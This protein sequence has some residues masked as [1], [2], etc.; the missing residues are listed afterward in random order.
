MVCT[1]ALSSSFFFFCI[2][3]SYLISTIVP[4]P[5]EQRCHRLQTKWIRK[6][7]TMLYSSVLYSVLY[8]EYKMNLMNAPFPWRSVGARCLL[9]ICRQRHCSFPRFKSASCFERDDFSRIFASKSCLGPIGQAVNGKAK[10]FQSRISQTH[11]HRNKTCVKK[12]AEKIHFDTYNSLWAAIRFQVYIYRISTTKAL[13]LSLSLSFCTTQVYLLSF[14]AIC[15]IYVEFMISFTV[16]SRS[17]NVLCAQLAH[18]DDALVVQPRDGRTLGDSG[19]DPCSSSVF[20]WL[21]KNP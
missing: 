18:R 8:Q 1:T 3:V 5:R 7:T 4:R 14:F 2:F 20:D 6:A 13:C 17:W 10:R 16:V 15:W 12:K 11:R 21:G 9:Y 19:D